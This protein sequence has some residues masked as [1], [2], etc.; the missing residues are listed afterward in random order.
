MERNAS[1]FRRSR[2][3]NQNATQLA[4]T[5]VP[6]SVKLWGNGF[7]A[8][9]A[10]DEKWEVLLIVHPMVM[11]FN[12][13]TQFLHH[14]LMKLQRSLELRTLINQAIKLFFEKVV[15]KVVKGWVQSHCI[16][17]VI[18]V[19]LHPCRKALSISMSFS[20]VFSVISSSPA[21]LACSSSKLRWN[22]VIVGSSDFR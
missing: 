18:F 5:S 12:G 11:G 7:P 22:A 21:S 15:K 20:R 6:P 9:L 13:I 8:K 19:Q 14:D 1:A 3:L 16:P 4:T 2:G 17:L 10:M